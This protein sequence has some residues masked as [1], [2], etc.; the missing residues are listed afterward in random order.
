MQNNVFFPK[1]FPKWQEG[2]HNYLVMGP[3]TKLLWEKSYLRRSKF[4]DTVT[5]VSLIVETTDGYWRFESMKPPHWPPVPSHWECVCLLWGC[6]TSH[7]KMVGNIMV[8]S[9]SISNIAD[10]NHGYRWVHFSH[11][12][13]HIFHVLPKLI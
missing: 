9:V 1:H 4:C 8:C 5:L 2:E 3:E 12:S 7:R 10:K 11:D 6:F 13:R